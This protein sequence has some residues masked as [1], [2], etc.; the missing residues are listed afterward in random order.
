MSVNTAA[1]AAYCVG[2]RPQLVWA[3]ESTAETEGHLYRHDAREHAHCW[4]FKLKSGF[5]QNEH[6]GSCVERTC[7]AMLQAYRIASATET[8]P[9]AVSQ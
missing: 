7:T 5:W 8:P 6:R 9:N 3:A 4:V 1:G 2:H